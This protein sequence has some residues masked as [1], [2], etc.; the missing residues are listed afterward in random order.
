LLIDHPSSDIESLYSEQ[1]SAYENTI[2][3]IEESEDED[4]LSLASLGDS[5]SSFPIFMSQQEAIPQ[6]I[7][8]TL[9][10]QTPHVQ[11]SLLTSKFSKPIKVIGLIDTGAA[12]TMVNP[13]LFPPEI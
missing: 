11:V 12:K 6:L 4:N 7:L 9:A 5:S 8:L 1:D 10:S 13:K 3:A 2:F